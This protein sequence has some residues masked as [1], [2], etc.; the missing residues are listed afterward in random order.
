MFK[1]IL[2]DFDGV[3]L[4][5]E[6]LHYE[7]FRRVFAEEGVSLARKAYYEDCLGFNDAECIRW[8]LEGTG[9]ID[10]AGGIE[11]LTER[12]SVY[13]EELLDKQMRFFPG[14]C[15]FIRAAA[16]KYPLAV[17]SMARRGEIEIALRR[18]ALSDLFCVIVSGEDIEKTKPDPE[19]YR[20]TL[21]LLNAR[22]ASTEIKQAIRPQE[23]LVVEDSC[24]G[25]QSAKAAGMNVLGLAQTEDAARLKA[26][27]RVLPSLEGVAPE[28]VEA[29]FGR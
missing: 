15:A 12:K 28:D 7:A 8:G 5:S 29:L 17:T 22:L 24:A 9:R 1:A 3:I 20:K 10:E 19:P 27:D 6:D 16:G 26:A 21:R 4:D 14:V 2:F 18:A 25:I 13:F 11:R 23:C